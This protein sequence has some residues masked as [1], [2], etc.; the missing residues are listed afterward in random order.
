M[1][2]KI[3]GIKIDT[4][5]PKTKDKIYYYK[6]E[7]DFKR[8]DKINVKVESGGAPDAV[9]VIGNSRKKI[10]HKLKDLEEV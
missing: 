10:S 3:V 4:K 1:K 2:S 8:G 9:V 6:T 5:S 7:K